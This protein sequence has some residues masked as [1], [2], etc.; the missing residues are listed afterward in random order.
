MVHEAVFVTPAEFKEKLKSTSLEGGVFSSPYGNLA[1]RR[2][3]GFICALAFIDLKPLDQWIYEQPYKESSFSLQTNDMEISQKLMLVGTPFQ[4]LVWKQLLMIPTGKVKFYQDIA[5][6]FSDSKK[7]R[8]VGS[9]VGANPIS[10][11]VP[12]HRVL[13]KSGGFGNY[14]W[15]PKIKEKLLKD[16]GYVFKT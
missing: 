16:E 3:E 2:F 5:I 11:L 8:A 6:A 13:P 12:C 10:W 1:I 15:G 7:S 4:H 14:H 9:A